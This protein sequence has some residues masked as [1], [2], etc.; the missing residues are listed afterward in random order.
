MIRS[1]N[2]FFDINFNFFHLDGRGHENTH[3]LFQTMGI[4]FFLLSFL[5]RLYPKLS[6]FP[7]GLRLILKMNGMDP[8]LFRPFQILWRVV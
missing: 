1:Q 6:Q 2:D 8:E 3:C 5:L 4:S 7:D